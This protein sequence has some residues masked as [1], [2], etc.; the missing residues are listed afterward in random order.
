MLS[1]YRSHP[2]DSFPTH[3]STTNVWVESPPCGCDVYH[4]NVQHCT[5]SKHTA[6]K[7]KK[8][9][10]L[11]A[12]ISREAW[13]YTRL[14]KSRQPSISSTH[15]GPKA[16]NLPHSNACSA[17][18]NCNQHTCLG[19]SLLVQTVY[20]ALW[21]KDETY[22]TGKPFLFLVYHHVVC[23]QLCKQCLK[24]AAELHA[25]VLTKNSIC[26]SSLVAIHNQF[27]SCPSFSA[28]Q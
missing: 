14:P 5:C 18:Q 8:M 12:L 7:E 9:I 28:K 13:E 27:N 23:A 26:W 21:P 17:H 10:H 22:R 15:S 4:D 3:V 16:G 20:V 25:S 1:W 6:Q 2:Q 24:W 11:L 19:L